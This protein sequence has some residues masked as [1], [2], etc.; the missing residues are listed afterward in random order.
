MISLT[1]AILK[2]KKIKLIQAKTA[3]CREAGVGAETNE[4]FL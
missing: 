3:G 1:C 2:K 4:L